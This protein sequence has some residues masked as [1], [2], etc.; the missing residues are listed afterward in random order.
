VPVHWHNDASQ[1]EIARGYAQY[2]EILAQQEND[3]LVGWGKPGPSKKRAPA[4][5]STPVEGVSASIHVPEGVR[6]TAHFAPAHD[7]DRGVNK[8]VA[9]DAEQAEAK[10]RRKTLMAQAVLDAA[11][12]PPDPDTRMGSPPVKLAPKTLPKTRTTLTVRAGGIMGGPND[13]HVISSQETDPIMQ[14]RQQVFADLANPNKV[15]RTPEIQGV[16]DQLNASLLPPAIAATSQ[17]SVPA[18]SLSYPIPH[19][20]LAQFPYIST[21]LSTYMSMPSS[22][23]AA[24]PSNP[25]S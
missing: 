25:P 12:L 4:V 6:K 9:T 3:P 24:L 18:P 15:K 17:S 19:L 7:S 23:V 11:P 21:A 14:A 5:P 10:K 1:D 20:D 16:L 2:I 22:L 13:P 8:G